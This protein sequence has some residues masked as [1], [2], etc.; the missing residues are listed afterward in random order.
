MICLRSTATKLEFTGA[1]EVNVCAEVAVTRAGNALVHICSTLLFT[2]TFLLTT[3]V[4]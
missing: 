2:L 3:V 1:A 4:L